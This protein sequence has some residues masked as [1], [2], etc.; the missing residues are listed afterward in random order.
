MPDNDPW[1]WST[2]DLVRE[3]CISR[4]IFR[5]LGCVEPYPDPEN[6]EQQLRVYRIT[7]NVFLA[8]L[9]PQTLRHDLKI[10]SPSES[11]ALA[12]VMR[13]LQSRSLK[14]KQHT[15][16]SDI[17]SLSINNNSQN[18]VP[19]SIARPGEINRKRARTTAE[20]PG[21]WDHLLRWAQ[22]DAGEDVNVVQQEEEDWAA[23]E[24]VDV[25]DDDNDV[26]AGAIEDDAPD[27]EDD[28][29]NQPFTQNRKG[30]LSQEQIVDIINESIENYTN[31]WIPG[32][33]E[34][35]EDLEPGRLVTC[36][37]PDRL[38]EKA[39]DSGQRQDL[40]HRYE[41]QAQYFQQRLDELCDEILKFP[42][43][44]VDAVRKQC[45]NL[46]VTVD[47]LEH[48]NWLASIYNLD[49]ADDS[50]EE[51]I[52]FEASL[53]GNAT[54]APNFRPDTLPEV[55][56]LD[57]LSDASELGNDHSASSQSPHS[58]VEEN[59]R[60]ESAPKT[61]RSTDEME[62][63]LVAIPTSSAQAPRG[64]APE[65]ASIAMVRQW[66]WEDLVR[67]QDRERAVSKAILEMSSERRETVR[68]RLRI[69]GRA[70]IIRETT[71]CIAMLVRGDQRMPGVLPRDSQK[72][73]TLT[74]LFLCWGLSQNCFH[75]TPN[76]ETLE[77]FAQHLE[78]DSSDLTRFYEYLN[79]ILITTFNPD[80][81]E[82]L[83]QPSQAEVITISDDEDDILR[84]PV[85][86]RRSSTT[87]II[88]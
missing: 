41:S 38:W 46:E 57:S 49:P 64:D 81:L 18:D 48:A 53:D 70:K 25:D 65:N 35:I 43:A 26:T 74:T 50:D 71:A 47:S 76:K 80:A 11:M 68:I 54:Q 51:S 58:I 52:D 86:R 87:I 55:I 45:C 4:S 69:L 1:D 85:K 10:S 59:S 44:N 79:A 29:Y 27:L 63:E 73:V 82:H 16:T 14:Y 5:T 6:L 72:I 88:D 32:K 13:V 12:T 77:G 8:A 7:G 37:D 24:L 39:E 42:G 15:A 84:R 33:D 20:A 28:N 83:E 34:I 62:H 2:D 30:K 36:Y 19:T 3:L 60:S 9:N 78:R 56:D 31:A 22:V 67:T 66:K 21:E 17:G 75:K 23:E 61:A 40:A